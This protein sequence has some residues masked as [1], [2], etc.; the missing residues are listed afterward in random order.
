VATI[1]LISAG[2]EKLVPSSR[3]TPSSPASPND[4]GEVKRRS[5]AAGFPRV[6]C[7]E[8]RP[9]G[10]PESAQAVPQQ[11]GVLLIIM[12]QVQPDFIIV[13]MQSQ[14]PW[15]MALQA[16]S[17]LVQ[18]TV[19]PLSVIS[20]LHMPIVSEQQ[21][22]I[23]PFIMQQQQQ[24][25]A[26]SMEHRLC[27][28]VQAMSSSQLQVIFM[29]PLIFCIL[30]VQRGTIIQFDGIAEGIPMP[31]APIPI[32]MPIPVIPIAARSIIMVAIR[33]SFPPASFPSGHSTGPGEKT[34]LAEYTESS[35]HLQQATA[36][37]LATTS[38]PCGT[39]R[40]SNH[41]VSPTLST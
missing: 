10:K 14:Q 17:P 29:P 9:A 36:R 18:V 8:G 19:Q 16:A 30:K 13:F 40:S 34:S 27:S 7:L 23:M 38:S 3:G 6:V 11:T 32:P 28:V 2:V 39:R 5:V 26:A 22:T 20:H 12:Q 1:L 15:I 24:G 31:G 21:Q 41:H 25:P 4:R 33:C 35:P 37:L